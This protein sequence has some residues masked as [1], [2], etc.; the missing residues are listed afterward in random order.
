MLRIRGTV[1]D[2]PVDLTLE[3][4]EGDW[5]RLGAQLQAA[6]APTATPVAPVKQT[7]DLWQSAQELLR[8]AGQLSGLEL[9]DQLEGLA[10]DAASG[11]RLLVRLRHS[12]NVKVASGADTPLY[13]WVG[14]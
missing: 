14:A 9:L 10:G 13:S 4:D 7:D 11:K 8:K 5:A 6:P 2:L 12:A 1:G 3:L